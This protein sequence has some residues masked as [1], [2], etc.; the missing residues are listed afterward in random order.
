MAEGGYDIEGFIMKD[1][2]VKVIVSH[3]AAVFP[4]IGGFICEVGGKASCALFGYFI[5]QSGDIGADFMVV[6]FIA[7]GIVEVVD[8]ISAVSVGAHHYPMDKGELIVIKL[9]FVDL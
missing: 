7:F 9:V 4:C 1:S 6:A 3:I 2:G 8:V 5:A